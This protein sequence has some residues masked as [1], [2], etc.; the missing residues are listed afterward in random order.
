MKEIS[1][2]KHNQKITRSFY[3]IGLPA[4][5]SGTLTNWISGIPVLPIVLFMTGI[6]LISLSDKK[7]WVRVLTIFLVP[8][9]IIFIIAII[10]PPL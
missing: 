3:W 7:K 1:K 8:F 9:V 2:R 4:L 10:M 5:I 6:F